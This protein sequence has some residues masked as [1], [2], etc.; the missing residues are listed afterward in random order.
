L[1]IIFFAILRLSN[2][3]LDLLESQYIHVVLVIKTYLLF[4][5]ILLLLLL[6]L[7]ILLPPPLIGDRGSTV[8]KVLRYKSEGR[9]FDP[10]WCHRIFDIKLSHRTMVL[11]ST[12]LLTEMST[13]R[14]AD[15]LTTILCRCHE[16]WEP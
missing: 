14:K 2:Y 4:L 6:L 3:T 13:R 10:R 15:N 1:K 5:L 11:W 7:L 9:W 16:I 8:V 12:Q